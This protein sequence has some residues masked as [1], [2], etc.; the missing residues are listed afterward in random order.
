MIISPFFSSPDPDLYQEGSLDPLGILPIWM[1]FGQDLFN[2][3]ITTIANDVRI[4]NFNLFHHYI[5][6]HL[7]RQNP[8]AMRVAKERYHDWRT[9]TDM[10][11]GLIIFLEQLVSHI[12]YLEG[13][14]NTSIETIGILGLNKARLAHATQSGSQ[15]ILRANKSSG[16]LKNQLILGMNGRYKGPM[17]NMGY[18]DRSFNY[19]P[20]AWSG[21]E[22]VISKWPE[23]Q[24]LVKAIHHLLMKE[25]LQSA[26]RTSPQLSFETLKSSNQFKTIRDGYLI[27]FG[28]K[29]LSS[30]LRAFWKDQLG[31]NSGGP[32]ILFELISKQA[33]KQP[34]AH[35]KVFREAHSL[36]K[37]EPTEQ[38]KIERILEIEPFLSAIEYLIRYLAQ[39]SVKNISDI[40][41]EVDIVKNTVIRYAGIQ[42]NAS[43]P[44]LNRLLE[45]VQWTGDRYT[46]LVNILGYHRQISLA[47][48]GSPWLELES[49]G[50]IRHH[51]A[52][53]LNDAYNTPQKYFIKPFWWHTYY[54]ETLRS[55]Y[56]GLA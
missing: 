29:R 53:I 30:L 44:R 43:V 3:R 23:A 33:E 28:K 56:N 25:L 14:H 12:F 37:R 7:F 46:W 55:V 27:C 5:L 16:L 17:M 31:L 39:P 20:N 1:H 8:E 52:P 36:L 42:P 50:N 49:N 21:F 35:E 18:F 47:R 2:N 38:Q 13:D 4:F 45:A 11:T 10:R 9:D 22:R 32:A 48:G 6:F 40:I 41:T 54:L 24:V 19:L 26:G 15:I 34:I 51:Y